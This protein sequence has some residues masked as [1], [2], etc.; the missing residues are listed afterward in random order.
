MK[1]K[2][3][4][5]IKRL[6]S[7]ALSLILTLA[8]GTAGI[9]HAAA[10]PDTP[11]APANPGQQTDTAIP[12]PKPVAK[13]KVVG[14]L[15]HMLAL[16]DDGTVY[17][18]GENKVGQ[19]GDNTYAKRANPVQ[20]KGI[21]DGEY[22]TDIIDIA[23][24]D[25]HSLALAKSGAVYAWGFDGRK[26]SDGNPA[27]DGVLGIGAINLFLSE[28]SEPAPVQVKGVGGSGH[29]TDIVTI[30]TSS[31]F[32][33]ALKKDGTVYAW[34]VDLNSCGTLGDGY[35]RN[36]STPIQVKGVGGTGYLTDIIAISAGATHTLALKKDGTVYAWGS[37]RD[38]ELGNGTNDEFSATPVLVK[39]VDGKGNLGEII[40]VAAGSQFSLALKKDG[41]V[42][43]WGHPSILG[44]DN[45]SHSSTPVQIKNAKGDGYLTGISSIAAGSLSAY[46]MDRGSVLAWG[47]NKYGQLGVNSTA[48]EIKTPTLMRNADGNIASII[49]I[50]ASKGDAL[51]VDYSGAVAASGRDI[52]YDSGSSVF[53]GPSG[54]KDNSTTSLT[55]VKGLDGVGNLYLIAYPLYVENGKGSGLYYPGTPVNIVATA[56]DRSKV[57]DRWVTSENYVTAQPVTFTNAYVY[58]TTITMQCL[59]Q[60]R[61]VYVAATYRDAG[62]ER[63]QIYTVTVNN[64]N[65][66]YSGAGKY[67]W[68]D[69]VSLDA[70][71]HGGGYIFKGWNVNVGDAEILNPTTFK[72]VFTMP[73]NDVTVTAVWEQDQDLMMIREWDDPFDDVPDDIWYYEGVKLAYQM[74]LMN[75]KSKVEFNPLDNLS[76][77]EAVTLA[78][79]MH[80]LYTTSRVTLEQSTGNWYDSYVEYAKVNGIIGD[81]MYQWT[82]PQ[83]TTTATRA[84]YMEIFARALPDEALPAINTIPD[85][86][87]PDVPTSHANA[88]AIYKLYRAGIVNGLDSAHRCGPDLNI[89][90]CEV[91]TIVVRMMIM[92]NRVTF[93]MSP[94]DAEPEP[95]EADPAAEPEPD[96]D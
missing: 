23:A 69:T 8:A 42:Y 65:S 20:V 19:V 35:I 43:A 75:G 10:T 16:R 26:E 79:R 53:G 27:T 56:P 37:N 82:P 4:A 95:S 93:T 11:A 49:S 24:G 87:I 61:Y 86:S 14:G 81:E 80:Q 84:G 32:S 46:A 92:E 96:T 29:L 83:W 52:L 70:G 45:P 67:Y 47:D 62:S 33:V 2:N 38:K 54:G 25:Y 88:A 63:A 13:P 17:A 9:M 74:G 48:A 94:A 6:T 76:Y 73:P 90:R 3:L 55:R 89:R 58:R 22:L 28:C 5:A 41:T 91:A 30:S 34:G 64:S 68:G 18:W 15:Y 50:G 59:L 66:A 85:E 31:N 7:L 39:G 77:A 72:A 78:A 12:E 21:G 57:F 71:T 1:R 36:S 60:G 44:S 51:A 40:S